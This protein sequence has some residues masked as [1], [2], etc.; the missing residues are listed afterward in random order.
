MPESCDEHTINLFCKTQ[1]SEIKGDLGAV[2]DAIVG[3]SKVGY[4][5]RIDRLEQ[6]RNSRSKMEW[7]IIACIVVILVNSA[8]S[9]AGRILGHLGSE[10]NDVVSKETK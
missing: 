5:V 10:H 9:L 6:A 4:N 1:F 8:W 7:L 3:N 2:K